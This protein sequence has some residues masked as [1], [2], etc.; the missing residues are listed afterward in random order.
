VVS[1]SRRAESR[2]SS[3]QIHHV[4]RDGKDYPATAVIFTNDLVMLRFAD[5]TVE[6]VIRITVK[7]TYFLEEVVSLTGPGV[8]EFVFAD[9]PLMLHGS[10]EE[11]FAAVALALNLQTLVPGIPQPGS[12]LHAACFRRFGFAGAQVAMIG[13]PSEKLRRVL[14]KRRGQNKGQNRTALS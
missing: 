10:P 6:A 8:Q 5:A 11:S 13:C 4:K 2:R 7:N 9:V 3:S 14:Q 12:H 1:Q